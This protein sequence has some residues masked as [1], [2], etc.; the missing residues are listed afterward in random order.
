MPTPDEFM[1]ELPAS[2][3]PRAASIRRLVLELAPH[4][5]ERLTWDAI[6]IYDPDRGGPVKGSIC[7]IVHRR[8]VLRLDFPL[9]EFMEDPRGLLRSEAGRRG[10]RFVQIDVDE[11]SEADL[12]SLIR[13]SLA[14]PPKPKRLPEPPGG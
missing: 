7:Q 10:K 3:R 13:A 14:A 12:R 2:L 11:P 8:G 9:G 1:M 6:S 5:A 4:A